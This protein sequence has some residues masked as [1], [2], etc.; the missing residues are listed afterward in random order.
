MCVVVDGLSRCDDDELRLENGR[1]AN[2]ICGRSTLLE[3]LAPALAVF[4]RL[5]YYCCSYNNVCIYTFTLQYCCPCF[6][7]E[8]DNTLENLNF[9][10]DF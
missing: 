2:Q 7:R 6:Y 3:S 1:A 8:P 4:V 5:L 10:P 9:F